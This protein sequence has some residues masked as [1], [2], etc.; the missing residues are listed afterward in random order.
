MNNS[1][2]INNKIFNINEQFPP[3]AI[4]EKIAILYTGGLKS[5]LLGLISKEIYG[6]DNIIFVFCSFEEFVS[7]SN[8]SPIFIKIQNNFT[9]GLKNLGALNFLQLNKDIYNSQEFIF[10]SI[11]NKITSKY[12]NVKYIFAGYN[13]LFEETKNLITNYGY[14]KGKTTVEELLRDL[15][16]NSSIY[17]ELYLDVNT[18]NFSIPATFPSKLDLNQLEN[19]YESVFKPFVGLTQVEILNFYQQLNLQ[20]K[21]FNTIDCESISQKSHCGKCG[22]CEKRKYMLSQLNIT[23]TTDYDVK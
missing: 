10:T 15:K 12:Q 8:N 23:D 22:Y 6:I 19:F 9:K 13:N 3:I 11:V 5:H 18:F 4:N 16:E 17:P 2:T 21:I 7:I 20:N 14:H 1:Y